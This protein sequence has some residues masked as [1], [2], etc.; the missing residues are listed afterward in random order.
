MNLEILKKIRSKFN[1]KDELAKKIDIDLSNIHLSID[2]EKILKE[3]TKDFFP[4][5][6]SWSSSEFAK[7]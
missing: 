3:A 6:G 7:R 4:K 2:E 1:K 5:S